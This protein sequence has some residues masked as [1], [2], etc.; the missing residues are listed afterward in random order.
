MGNIKGRKL[1]TKLFLFSIFFGI[2]NANYLF[3]HPMTP[4]IIISYA[5]DFYVSHYV[6][7]CASP[8]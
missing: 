4:K 2:F 8:K 3:S 6:L 5:Y 1:T 7:L